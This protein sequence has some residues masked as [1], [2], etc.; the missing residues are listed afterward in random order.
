MFIAK[1]KNMQFISHPKVYC[2]LH[3]K[4]HFNRHIHNLFVLKSITSQTRLY[5]SRMGL[6]WHTQQ[7][8]RAGPGACCV[9]MLAFTTGSGACYVFQFSYTS[10][11]P[12]IPIGIHNRPRGMLC[13]PVARA[14]CVCSILFILYM[15]FVSV[16]ISFTTSLTRTVNMFFSTSTPISKISLKVRPL[17]YWSVH[18]FFYNLIQ[19]PKFYYPPYFIFPKQIFN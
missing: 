1:R 10:G 16:S 18:I 5:G 15:K 14:Y 4:P 3:V 9:C 19:H 6:C 7:E 17:T 8:Y 2:T 12:C 11:L 13:M